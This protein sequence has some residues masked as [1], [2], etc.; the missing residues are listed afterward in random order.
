VLDPQASREGFGAGEA[1]VAA[2]EIVA[3]PRLARRS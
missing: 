3:A 2:L 1:V